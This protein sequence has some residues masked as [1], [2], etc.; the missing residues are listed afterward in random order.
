M[1]GDADEPVRG[2]GR[3]IGQD[4]QLR[5]AERNKLPDSTG[6]LELATC[7]R[8]WSFFPRRFAP[9]AG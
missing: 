8:D 7:T 3:G 6:L 5:G 2:A 1:T 9:T 4:L